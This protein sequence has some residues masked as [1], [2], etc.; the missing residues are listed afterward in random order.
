MTDAEIIAVLQRNY[1]PA[2]V[3]AI[4]NALRGRPEVETLELLERAAGMRGWPAP[5]LVNRLIWEVG[6]LRRLTGL[7]YDRCDAT[8]ARFVLEFSAA[9]LGRERAERELRDAV[10]RRPQLRPLVAYWLPGEWGVPAA[11]VDAFLAIGE[12]ET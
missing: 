6:L 9:R 12:E 1:G 11:E 10:R 8:S 4:A 5:D 3:N 7:M 2:E